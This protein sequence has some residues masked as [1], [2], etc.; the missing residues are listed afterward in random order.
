MT[1]WVWCDKPL[2]LARGLG[3]HFG[4]EKRLR[5][6]P[7]DAF[8]AQLLA[9]IDLPAGLAFTGLREYVILGLGG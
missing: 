2:S 6:L 4:H 3:D 8:D 9:R 1:K 5:P 7:W